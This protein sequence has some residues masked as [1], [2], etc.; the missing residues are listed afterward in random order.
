MQHGTE[1]RHMWSRLKSNKL[2]RVDVVRVAVVNAMVRNEFFLCA[3]RTGDQSPETSS[4]TER[5]RTPGRSPGVQTTYLPSYMVSWKEH[6]MSLGSSELKVE[7]KRQ[8]GCFVAR[9]LS[10][11]FIWWTVTLLLC[12]ALHGSARL[13]SIDDVWLFRFSVALNV[14]S[15]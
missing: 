6:L 8:R 2:D 15:T 10:V 12:T 9:W 5:S 7:M 11:V 4:C 13:G 14:R 1:Q 3:D